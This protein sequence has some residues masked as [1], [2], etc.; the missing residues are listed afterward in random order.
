[1]TN[2]NCKIEDTCIADLNRM[3]YF[4]EKNMYKQL[5]DELMLTEYVQTNPCT[6]KDNIF[7]TPTKADINSMPDVSYAHHIF[8][9]REKD[10]IEQN[11]RL[12]NSINVI[13]YYLNP[14]D[15]KVCKPIK[16]TETKTNTEIIE[17]IIRLI[18]RNIQQGYKYPLH[19][20]I[21]CPTKNENL[22]DNNEGQMKINKLTL[23]MD[24]NEGCYIDVSEF[25]VHNWTHNDYRIYLDTRA[26]PPHS[27][28][29][30]LTDGMGFIGTY[31]N[32]YVNHSPGDPI[33]MNGLV[34]GEE[35]DLYADERII[36]FLNELSI[37]KINRPMETLMEKIN[38]RLS[39][40]LD[41][42]FYAS[43]INHAVRQLKEDGHWPEID[44]D[45]K[46]K[47]LTQL[48]ITHNSELFQ[49]HARGDKRDWNA[50]Y[51]NRF[52]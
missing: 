12:S 41:E 32:M 18:E 21:L 9:K 27:L 11:K 19:G 23:G 39:K 17:G 8:T 15:F 29:N 35:H 30:M 24:D 47:H 38:D 1:M 2:L 14:Y 25:G 42:S 52:D 31:H 45:L 7:I 22:F 5:S 40:E 20:F 28:S 50:I 26:E 13:P 4:A 34:L 10:A 44:S 3:I 46:N 43:S 36:S 37:S 48:E 49:T 16:L 51:H 6:S 33:T